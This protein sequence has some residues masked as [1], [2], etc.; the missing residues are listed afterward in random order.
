[1]YG[2]DVPSFHFKCVDEERI[3][4][5]LRNINLNKRAGYDNIPGK[6]ISL[7]HSALAPVLTHLVYLCIKSSKY[8]TNMKLAELSPMYKNDDNLMKENY[9]PVSVLT[10]LSKLQESVVNDQLYMYFVEIFE[11]LLSA[12]RK[13]YSCQSV[14]TKMI[15]GWML[16]IVENEIVGALFMDLS[17]AFDRLPHS[18]FIAKL[19]AYG[20]SFDS[21]ELLSSYLS[22]RIQRVTKGVP[23]GSI[24]GPLLFNIFINDMFFF[25]D[26]CT[27]YNY[28]D[29]NS[30]SVSSTCTKSFTKRFSIQFNSI[31]FNSKR[32]I[33]THTYVQQSYT[34][35]VSRC[36]QTL[37]T[38][39]KQK[40]IK[41]RHSETCESM[42]ILEAVKGLWVLYLAL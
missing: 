38:R 28:A 13:K 12:F 17:K 24:I 27:L 21:C 14:L 23:Q 39:C 6:L 34:M 35:T 25:I 4:N 42:R 15:E 5:K 40:C 2:K 7:A 36:L 3:S 9:R 29:D 26:H 11:K 22:D 32:F 10:I 16:A 30:M 31:Q 1:M 37:G 41:F 18:L 8:P 20:L 19:H 33:E